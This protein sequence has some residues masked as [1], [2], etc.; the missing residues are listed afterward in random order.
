M[1]E[2]IAITKLS[3]IEGDIK[4]FIEKHQQKYKEQ[5]CRLLTVEQML[6]ARG[7]GIGPF[8]GSDKSLGALVTSAE[9]FAAF[10]KGARSSGQIDAGS[11]HRKA[12]NVVTGRGASAQITDLSW[13]HLDSPGSHFGI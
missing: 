1:D 11:F 3:A 7:T 5:D 8:N 12:V 4:R 6:T 13:R 9:G 2:S 10:K